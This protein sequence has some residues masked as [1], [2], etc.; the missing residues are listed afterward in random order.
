[1]DFCTASTRTGLQHFKYGG[2]S[3]MH[4]PRAV[5]LNLSTTDTLDWVLLCC[6][7]A[8]GGLCTV[9]C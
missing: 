2:A 1:M 3:F 5:F 8:G 7:G 6:G 4:T 9:G